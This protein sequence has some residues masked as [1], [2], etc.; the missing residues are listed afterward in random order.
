MDGFIMEN[1]KNESA[2]PTIY[3]GRNQGL[4]QDADG[5][6][7]YSNFGYNAKRE[8]KSGKT[9]YIKSYVL[10]R[11]TEKKGVAIY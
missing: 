1:T 2:Y 9:F 4:D 5:N 3:N 6:F 10:L 11:K 7:R 8:I